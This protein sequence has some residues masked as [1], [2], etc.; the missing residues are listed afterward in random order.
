M[1][2]LG[3]TNVETNI[4]EPRSLRAAAC[5]QGHLVS[6][7]ISGQLTEKGIYSIGDRSDDRYEYEYLFYGRR[8]FRTD[9]PE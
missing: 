6:L 4:D 7:S 9:T 1:D 3:L 5:F 8:D 2:T